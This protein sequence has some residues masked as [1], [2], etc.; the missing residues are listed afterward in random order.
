M[1]KKR[2]SLKARIITAKVTADDLI[3]RKAQME[4]YYHTL[5]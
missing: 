3:W 4:F 5:Q 2:D 1:S